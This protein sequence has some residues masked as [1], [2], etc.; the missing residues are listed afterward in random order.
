MQST[1]GEVKPDNLMCELQKSEVSQIDLSTNGN[2][3]DPRN[4]QF[5]HVLQR[6]P[7]TNKFRQNYQMIIQV[8]QIQAEIVCTHHNGILLCSVVGLRNN[9]RSIESNLALG[10]H[11]KLISLTTRRLLHVSRHLEAIV[12][13]NLFRREIT[14]NSGVITTRKSADGALRSLSQYGSGDTQHDSYSFG[15]KYGHFGSVRRQG[16]RPLFLSFFFHLF[17]FVLANSTKVTPYKNYDH[18]FSIYPLHC[19]RHRCIIKYC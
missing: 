5:S 12:V 14:T 10:L 7:A 17:W 13:F 2:L 11:E 6:E 9:G 3:P 4:Q 1:G 8:P 19:C 16:T 18:K 15:G